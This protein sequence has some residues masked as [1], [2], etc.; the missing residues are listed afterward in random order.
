MFPLSIQWGP[1]KSPPRPLPGGGIH[2]AVAAFYPLHLQAELTSDAL[3]RREEKKKKKKCA[4]TQERK[5]KTLIS[6]LVFFLEMSPPLMHQIIR[7]TSPLLF[8]LALAARVD[9]ANVNL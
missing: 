4:V 6:P 7:I 8:A 5:K 1:H 9:Q 3:Y 2:V